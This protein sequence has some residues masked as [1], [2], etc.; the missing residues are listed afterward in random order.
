M[1][2]FL[3]QKHSTCIITPNFLLVNLHLHKLPDTIISCPSYIFPS[4]K[5][6]TIPASQHAVQWHSPHHPSSSAL[7][8]P[9]DL[10]ALKPLY[11]RFNKLPALSY[12]VLPAFQH[13]HQRCLA[14]APHMRKRTHT[15][16]HTHTT[17]LHGVKAHKAADVFIVDDAQVD[18]KKSNQ[19]AKR[20]G[21]VGGLHYCSV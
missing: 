7:W 3:H 13:R 11:L 21:V 6:P 16:I 17:Y 5:R 4:I 2:S 1:Q 18:S 12:P 9:E 14:G 19:G 15:H 8:L 20:K 10:F